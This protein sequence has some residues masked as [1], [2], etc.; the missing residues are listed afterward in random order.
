[1][2]E[3]FEIEELLTE[4]Q[5]T[6]AKIVRKYGLQESNFIKRMKISVRDNSI[7]VILPNYVKF[8]DEGRS[9]GRKPPI[10]DIVDWLN[11][12]G[13]SI[14][15][16]IS[17]DSYASAIANSI[18][19]KGIEARPFLDDFLEA[20]ITIISEKILNGIFDKINEE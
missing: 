11:Q 16:G 10:E 4:F 9:S 17:Q 12:K 8:V 2:N 20:L 18:G 13:I 6:L 3:E 1:M 5:S 19:K 14:P 7:K 15:N